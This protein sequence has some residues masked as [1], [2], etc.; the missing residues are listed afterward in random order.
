[1]IRSLEKIENYIEKNNIILDTCKE[2]EKFGKSALY[3]HINDKD[4]VLLSNSYH[5]KPTEEKL[6]I[7]LEEIGHYATSVGDTFK[8]NNTTSEK[9]IHDKCEK[10]AVIWGANFLITE[11]D[12]KKYISISD[13]VEELT[14]YLGVTQFI[15][16]EHLY[17]L[18]NKKRYIYLDNGKVDLYRLP[19]I[20][21]E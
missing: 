13:S 9:I 15:L 10:K 7:L 8:E 12:I 4:I 16:Y 21:I 1:M 3:C 14:E 17:N 6:E 2:L 18:R 20:C 11:D 19:N 5:T